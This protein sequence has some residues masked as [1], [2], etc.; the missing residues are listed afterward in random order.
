MK[1]LLTT[2]HA[3]YSHASLALPCLAAYCQDISHTEIIIREWT[4]NEP[5]EH[6]L[7]LVMAEQADL[8]AFSCYIWN[9]EQT[10]RIIS[11]IKKISPHTRIVL[12]G[13]EVSFGT[14]DLM[15][16][17]GAID[18]VIKGE[19]EETFRQLI[20]ALIQD[21]ASLRHD[22]LDE[23]GNLFFRDGTD[24]VSGPLN[25]NN[26]EL[27][28]L[29]SPFKAGLIDFS[30]PLVYYETSRG[31]P[32]SCAFC[33]SSVEGAVRTFSLDRIKED[34]LFLMS[35][36]IPQIKLVD[37]TF[38]YDAGRA[39]MLWEFILEH[40]R[41]S[42][43]HFEISADL[44]TDHNLKVLAHVPE[45]TFRFE[46]GIQSASQSTLAQVKRSAD[47]Q[48]IFTNV[49]RLMTETSIEL[50]LDLIAGL[51]GEN[52][53]GFLESLQTVADLHAHDIQIEPLKL[54]KGSPMREVEHYEEY[55][56]SEFPPYTI[57]RNPWLSYEDICRIETIGRL[58]DLFNK[59][60]GM[61]AAFRILQCRKQL[62]SILD[63]MARRAG[64]QNLSSLSCRK[65][66]ELFA[67]L[68]EPLPDS[69]D[70]AA[71][72]DALFFDYCRS[73]MPLMGKLPS[74]AV[75]NQKK[76]SWPA[77]RDL[78]D[79]LNLPP[80]SRVKSFR[81]EFRRDYRSEQENNG[82][83]TVTFIYISG[84]GRGLQVVVSTAGSTHS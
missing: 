59:H 68:A 40:N 61:T 81:Y 62:S 83:V 5:R 63:H 71:L 18:F 66:F 7:K 82:P 36:R 29:P 12:G 20:I 73:E 64:N 44:L 80:D 38:N 51:P 21:N 4:V 53:E 54:L 77:L 13:P 1:I 41:N 55:C 35:T 43:F 70:S 50:H 76:C 75:D 10:L 39:D 65:V 67:R 27:D 47:L 46:I 19:G 84:A 14:F 42:H 74:F 34:L 3:K 23:I 45:N 31:C 24:T 6:L 57:L 49:R 60:G 58:L 25:K 56:F 69:C 2:L 22:R 11:D 16:G 17:N 28:R 15:H 30:K 8:V 9:I 78:P 32:F 48:R 33:L 37:R 79:G 26:M 72:Y 52:Y